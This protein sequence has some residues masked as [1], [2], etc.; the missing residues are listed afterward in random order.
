[1]EFT[2]NG[3]DISALP[4]V[5]EVNWTPLEPSYARSLTWQWIVSWLSFLLIFAIT[6]YF[7]SALQKPLVYIP[8]AAGI[9]LFHFAGWLISRKSFF[10]KAY[11]LREKDILY[12]SGWITHH[13][14]VCP[15]SRVQ[16]CS[17]SSGP[18]DRRFKLATLRIYTAGSDGDMV[19][20]GL[21]ETT[22][23]SIK[24]YLSKKTG[25]EDEQP[26]I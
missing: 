6:A 2:N 1:M 14:S 5:E 12:R 8:A 15:F 21:E 13:V 7:I 4:R 19:I 23:F 26:G 3:V 18:L 16:H 11:A 17:V 9:T 10:L 24:A 25:E 22:A 20:P